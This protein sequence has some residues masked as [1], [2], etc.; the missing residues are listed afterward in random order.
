MYRILYG[1]IHLHFTHQIEFGSP[2]QVRTGSRCSRGI[3]G[4]LLASNYQKYRTA[5]SREK[6]ELFHVVKNIE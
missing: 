6:T 1:F 3:G 4:I 5:G 2:G